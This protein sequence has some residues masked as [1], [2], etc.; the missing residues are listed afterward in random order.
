LRARK[1][2]AN[3]FVADQSGRQCIAGSV[4]TCISIKDDRA[5]HGG[6]L[7]LTMLRLSQSPAFWRLIGIQSA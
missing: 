1:I 5:N 4:R 7:A 3:S 2:S 6:V